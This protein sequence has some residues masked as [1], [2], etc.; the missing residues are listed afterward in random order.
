M[1][2]A[3]VV[4]L[5]GVM[6]PV[7]AGHA[8]I[9]TSQTADDPAL[10]TSFASRNTKQHRRVFDGWAEP[11]GDWQRAGVYQ[12]ASSVQMPDICVSASSSMILY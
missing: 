7:A 2:R 11:S 10:T 8:R 9:V 6:G 5:L 3:T 12:A 4:M 1:I